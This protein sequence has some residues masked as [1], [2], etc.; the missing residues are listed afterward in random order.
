M[1]LIAAV[2]QALLYASSAVTA[3][4]KQGKVFKNNDLLTF[5]ED[6]ATAHANYLQ[7]V[8]I[9]QAERMR[10]PTETQCIGDKVKILIS[11]F[12]HIEKNKQTNNTNKVFS[13][14]HY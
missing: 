5:C 9:L 7:A 14:P 4:E 3:D 13:N 6:Y 12:F 10:C 1:M 11:K 2:K 8:E